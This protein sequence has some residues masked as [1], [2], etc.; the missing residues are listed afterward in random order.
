VARIARLFNPQVI[1]A[2]VVLLLCGGWGAPRTALANRLYLAND[3]H[4]DYGWNATTQMYDAAMLSELDY[5]LAQIA[6]T[7]GNPAAEQGRFNTDG[8][9]YLYLYE[10]NRNGVQFQQLIDAMK[11]GHITVPL[12]PFITLYG[13]LPTEAAVRAGYYPGRI[14]RRYAVPFL[15]A[16]E[17]ENA[18]I[19]WG[20]ASIWTGSG[21]RYSWKGLCG[22]ATRAPYNNRTDEVFRW[23]GPDDSELL[24]KWYYLTGGPRSWGGA[25][26]A[27]DNLSLFAVQTTISHF[28]SQPP[29]LP[30]VG[31]FG[32]G[33]T[34]VSYKT[35]AF[36]SLAHAWNQAHPGGDQVIVSNEVDYFEELEN[37]RASLNVLRGGWG[38][39]WDGWPAALS[40][41]TAQTRRAIERL[42]T[43]EA[44]AAIV[45]T[46]D[47]GFWPTRQANLEAG[48][49]DYFKYFEETWDDGGV[50]IEYVKYNKFS[51]AQHVD[52]AVTQAETAALTA[53]AGYFSTPDENRFLVFNPLAFSRTDFADLPVPGTGPFVVTDVATDSEVPSQ[54]VTRGGSMYLR[55]LASDVPS[56]GYRTYRYAPGSPAPWPNAAVVSGSRIEN[57]LYRVDIGAAGQ[58]ASAFDKTADRDLAGTGLND[59]GGG[60]AGSF[61]A[62]NVG[63]VSA[64]LRVEIGGWP[65]RRTRITLFRNVNRIAIDNEI[66][67]NST[68]N[69]WYRYHV[70]MTAP[71]IHFEEVGAIARPGLVTQGGD[72][73]P[74]TRADLMTLNHFVNFTANHYNVTLSNWDAFAMRV[75]SSTATTFQLPASD[76]S[77]LALGNP[78][79]S[80]IYDQGGDTYFLNRFALVGASGD[81][82][83]SQSMMTS[84]AHQ[85]PLRAIALPRN[86]TGPLSAT[87]A[88]FLSVSSPNVV[89]TAFK[90]A[91]EGERGLVVRLWELDGTPT[92]F[93]IDASAFTPASA[94]EVSLIETDIAPATLQA[95]SITASIGAHQL[96]AYRFVPGAAVP[97]ATPT[98]SATPAP[99]ATATVKP[100]A[101]P[102]LTASPT[103]SPPVSATATPLVTLTPVVRPGDVNGDGRIAADD[104]Q[105]LI[106]A[107][108]EPNPPPAADVQADGGVTTG[109]ITAL[110]RLLTAP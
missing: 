82:S 85:N 30:I 102:T 59:F 20:L 25:S 79:S 34:D 54:I 19:P 35:D 2:A 101:S 44:A 69:S 93:S 75:G 5:Y 81:F 106:E 95:G 56:L 91:E 41:R 99:T 13:A 24:M 58:I 7:A 26:E 12:N 72:F 18:T 15:I 49:V 64:T 100:S 16:E 92:S 94:Y 62:E 77:V 27:R 70:N 78:S 83:A 45:H 109:D 110:V 32:A 28:Q 104:L 6:A 90:P 76:I 84:L 17:M 51:W 3:N 37:Y 73:Q 68:S 36:V 23:R 74:G 31:L 66:L 14:A 63:P 55:I 57:D 67:Q 4:T 98:R 97:T 48:L 87:T 60:T 65:T 46:L 47:A 88:S 103:A 38:N 50:G 61:V 108:F 52:T 9:F 89:V 39:D 105:A 22:C 11:S 71:E 43:A 8:W 86:Q 96:K 107:L 53:L 33:W 42:R 21:V 80:D 29:Y 40:E 1:R 10:H